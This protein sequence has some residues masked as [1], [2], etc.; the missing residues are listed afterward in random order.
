MAAAWPAPAMRR[1]A[2][3]A[4]SLPR[5]A[6]A[7]PPGAQPGAGAGEQRPPGEVLLHLAWRRSEAGVA[8][9]S[10]VAR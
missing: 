7:P 10:A 5:S 2:A 8:A 4:S 9:P 1:R 6:S 3:T